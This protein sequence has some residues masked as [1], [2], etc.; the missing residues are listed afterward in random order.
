MT[1]RHVQLDDL[2]KPSVVRRADKGTF[3]IL[4]ITMH[5]GL[6]NQA[7]KFKKRVAS[8]DTSQYKVVARNQLV[9]G[10]PID[11]GV[12]S[13][14]NLYE[15]AIVSPAYDIWELKGNEEV[16]SRY[17]ER[18]L[19]S[20]RALFFYASKL[21][22]TAARRRTLPDDLFLSLSVPL[23][24]LQEQRRI[25][26]MLDKAAELRAKR[27]KALAQ[28]DILAKSTFLHLFGD[29]DRD[30]GRWP[31]VMFDDIVFDT[32]LGLVRGSQELGPDYPFPY[33]R[34]NAITREG[35]LDLS[36]IQRTHATDEEAN[37]YRLAPGDFLFNTR[38]SE[39]LV[40]KTALFRGSGLYLFNN[41]L[42]R[43]RFPA[44]VEA[45]FVA[46]VF[47]TPFVQRQLKLRKSGT[48]NVF[49]IYY[50]DLRS[51]L[52]P[53]PPTQLQRDFARRAAIVEK[54]KSAHRA[55]LAE[56]HALFVSLQHRAFRGEL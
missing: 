30:P 55:S 25:V 49:A 32:K 34:M 28:L 40:G 29:P 31:I 54:L 48:T 56:L 38:N 19:R 24:P 3:P 20:P 15:E 53:L 42:M 5:E 44:E 6:V 35:Q 50:K 10:F 8:S 45:E 41:N 13:F 14:Q 16:E 37:A 1:L 4:S 22:G 52:L 47:Q 7:D 23:P 46:A 17:L 2:I 36:G 21:R 43:I 27:R 26:G 9:V 33:V 51:L 18:F 39:E 11:E 12:L